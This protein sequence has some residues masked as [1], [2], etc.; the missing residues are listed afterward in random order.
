MHCVACRVAKYHDKH[1]ECAPA[2]VE[3]GRALLRKAQQADDPFGSKLPCEGG[4]QDAAKPAVAM[5]GADEKEV[6]IEDDDEKEPSA[7][8]EAAATTAEGGDD[9]ADAEGEEEEAGEEADDLELAFQSLEMARLIYE[10]VRSV[11]AVSRRVQCL[12]TIY[13]PARRW[14]LSLAQFLLLQFPDKEL[15][16]ADV[17]EYLGEVN[18]ENEMWHEA[19]TEL[20]KSLELKQRHLPPDHRQLAHL[21]YQIATAT[22]SLIESKRQQVKHHFESAAGVLRE[23][24]HAAGSRAGDSSASAGEESE[25]REL[26]AEIE[27]RVAEHS[28]QNN[29]PLT[30]PKPGR[31]TSLTTSSAMIS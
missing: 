16:L 29:L 3:Y 27:E 9:G 14:C 8:Q 1:I 2:W 6:E 31:R 28:Q 4:A 24:L 26:L 21:H 12:E 10:Q 22:V 23:R 15:E 17:L 19:V 7:D 30:V 25:L 13:P 11:L 20:E 18:M 5:D